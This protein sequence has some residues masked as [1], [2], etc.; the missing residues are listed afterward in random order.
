M[1]PQESQLKENISFNFKRLCKY[2]LRYS[3]SLEDLKDKVEIETEDA[4]LLRAFDYS[5][6]YIHVQFHDLE[7]EKPLKM[8]LLWQIH[9]WKTYHHKVMMDKKKA[10]R[11]RRQRCI[12]TEN[13]ELVCKILCRQNDFTYPEDSYIYRPLATKIA[14]E[15]N[16]VLAAKFGI[17]L[18]ELRD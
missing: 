11:E 8:P 14:V 16:K 1:P 5:E 6:Q 12:V 4:L 13:I 18:D 2:L 15:K 3:T 17:T 7:T 9:E 10:D